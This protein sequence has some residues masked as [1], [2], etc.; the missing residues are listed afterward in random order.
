MET[1]KE[2]KEVRESEK[3][4]EMK[5]E[6]AIEQIKILDLDFEASMVRGNCP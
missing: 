2:V 1:E 4:I 5:V 3:E 6:A